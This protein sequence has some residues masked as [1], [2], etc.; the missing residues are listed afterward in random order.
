M[1]VFRWTDSANK[2]AVALAEGRTQAEAGKEAGVTDRTIRNWLGIPAFVQ[3]VDALTLMTG[4]ATR[5]ER[6]RM[7]KKVIRQRVR[8]DGFIYSD[9]DVLDWLKFAQGETDGVKLNLVTALTEA[10]D[11][12]LAGSGPGGTDTN[13]SLPAEGDGAAT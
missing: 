13:T 10:A 3:E 2:A 9:K 6:I 11:N 5:A 1:S 12:I 8:D 7:A 4:I